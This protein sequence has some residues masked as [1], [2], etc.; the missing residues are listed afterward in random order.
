MKDIII[1]GTGGNCVDILDSIL[2]L[3]LEKKDPLYNPIGFLDDNKE[4][5]GKKIS[6][7]PVLG[8]LDR[9]SDY[10]DCFFVNGIG[11]PKNYWKKEV[12]ISKTKIPLERFETIIHPTASVSK[13]A[14]LGKGVVV[15]QNVTISNNA[16]VGNH[17]IIL[18]NS[19]ISHDT[20]IGSFSCITGGVC[21]SGI[22]SVGKSCYLGTNS[23]IIG[24]VEIG[25]N[26][27][28]GMGSVILENVPQNSIYVG[29]PGKFLRKVDL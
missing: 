21:I 5:W 8:S 23:S 22:V 2:E 14:K 7:L 4:L 25:D 24:G 18:P 12:I 13:M 29:N 16:S 15:L 9:A 26:S 19:I 11:S 1:L 20:S 10:N 27:L 6:G 17:V 28:I 3:N